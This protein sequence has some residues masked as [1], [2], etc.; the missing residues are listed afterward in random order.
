[1]RILSLLL[2]LVLA[3]P[4]PTR[5]AP[6]RVLV[7]IPP[8]AWF[9][10]QVAG[11]AAEVEVMVPPGASPHVYEPKPG[12]MTKVAGADLYLAVGVEFEDV[13]LP[14]F[15]GVNPAL[16][17]VHLDR[18]IRKLPMAAHH[19]E[20][21]EHGH[22]DAHHEDLDHEAMHAD[23]DHED[24]EAMHADADHHDGMA[25][26]HG[27]GHMDAEHEE[28]GDHHA[29]DHH[30]ED[31]EHHG[32]D[33][34]HHE[35]AMAEHHDHEAMHTDPDH[36]DE[37]VEH[38]GLDPHIWLSPRLA[39]VMVLNIE[40]ALAHARPA[41]AELFEANAQRTFA[42]IEALEHDLASLFADLPSRRFVVFHPSWGYFA[43]EFD[44]VQMP[45]ETEGR[46]PS[47]RELHDL[48]AEA[49]EHNVRAVFVQP[50]MSQRT[51]SIVAGELSGRVVVADP[52]AADWAANLSRVARE[53][54]AAMKET[55]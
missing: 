51:A 10:R 31:G 50:Q 11:D 45:I 32:A 19:H 41:Q 8:A 25:E 2:L 3:L 46:E 39:R 4:L 55:R 47:P 36:S 5:A 18:G 40:H 30:G 26:Q 16:E 37:M 34:E 38:H 29:G 15:T 9:V 52:L 7:S 28:H 1:M 48:L 54:A 14:R 35:A 27:H 49:R 42:A 12:Q 6:L 24:H 23:A 44:L 17:V 22:M 13:W 33:G 21:G 20:G 43:H 53:M